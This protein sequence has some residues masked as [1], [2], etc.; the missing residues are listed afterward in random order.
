MMGC[1]DL[2]FCWRYNIDIFRVYVFRCWTQPL[3]YVSSSLL[4]T[5][6]HTEFLLGYVLTQ[7]SI[8]LALS[9]VRLALYLYSLD[10]HKLNHNQP[11]MC[12]LK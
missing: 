10:I 12:D 2:S 9:Q 5:G 11:Y 3:E 8:T 7:S 4:E 1:A 6:H